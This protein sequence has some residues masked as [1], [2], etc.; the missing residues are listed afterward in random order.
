MSSKDVAK[1]LENPSEMML[2]VIGRME[3]MEKA[4]QI[5]IADELFGGS[6]GE[7][8]V[9]LLSQGEVG[10]RRTIDRAREVGAVLDSEMIEKAQ[11]VDRRFSELSTRVG[12]W[13]KMLAVDIADL[14]LDLL[15]TRLDDIFGSEAA[16]RSILGDKAVDEMKMAAEVTEEHAKVATDLRGAYLEVSDAARRVGIELSEAHC[17]RWRWEMLTFRRCFWACPMRRRLYLLA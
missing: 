8:F 16:A 15:E 14:P 9:E 6:A 2:E 7:R 12:G 4:A 1:A 10:L 3:G 5:R 13:F 17:M 11:E